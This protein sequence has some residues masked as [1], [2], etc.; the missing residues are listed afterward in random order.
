MS[1]TQ[2]YP[3]SSFWSLILLWIEEEQGILESRS[4]QAIEREDKSLCKSA[5]AKKKKSHNDR[6][7]N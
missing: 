4:F 3:E 1:T 2:M 7:V 5:F 6:T